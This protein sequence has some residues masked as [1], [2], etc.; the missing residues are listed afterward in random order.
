MPQ[1]SAPDRGLPPVRTLEGYAGVFEQHRRRLY[2]LARLLAHDPVVAEDVVANAFVR[3]YEP[4]TDGRVRD[5]G[6]YLRSAVVNGVTEWGRTRQSN[7]DRQSRLGLAAPVDDPA[8]PVADRLVLLAA[9]DQ[10]P[11]SSREVLVLRFYGDCS[12]SET[13]E[14]LGIRPGTVKSRTARSLER[15]REVLGEE[16]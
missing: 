2:G 16:I 10:L 1:L 11:R 8:G 14:L 3:T 15:L 9:L 13:A 4:W 6:A 12:V 5:V 7:Q